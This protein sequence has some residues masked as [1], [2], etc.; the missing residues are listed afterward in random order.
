MGL[1]I[2]EILIILGILGGLAWAIYNRLHPNRDQY[3]P[4]I[5][6]VGGPPR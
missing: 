4:G 5:R 1:D 6:L 3:G 2:G